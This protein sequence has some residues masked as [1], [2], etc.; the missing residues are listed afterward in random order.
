[1][2]I[3]ETFLK[4][5][6]EAVKNFGNETAVVAPDGKLTYKELDELS[7]AFSKTVK[8]H[9]FVPLEAGRSKNYIVEAIGVMKA[10]AAFVPVDP[11]YPQERKDYMISDCAN[12]VAKD[13]L[14]LMIYTSG[15]T[16]RPKGV[17]ISHSALAA[18]IAASEEN[19]DFGKGVNYAQLASFSFVMSLHDIFPLLT[20]GGCLHILDDATRKDLSALNRY[21]NENHIDGLTGNPQMGKMLIEQF[22]PKLKFMCL[23]GEKVSEMPKTDI[24]IINGYGCT[25]YTS[26][27]LEYV[28]K[29]GETNVPVGRPVAN[30]QVFICD[31]GMNVVEKGEIGELC[32]A[33]PQLAEG[34]HNREDLTAEKFVEFQG[35]RVYKTGDLARC[36]ENDDIEYCGRK[37]FL[38]KIRGFR[39]EPGEIE[40]VAK[41]CD[42]VTN[43]VA[44]DCRINGVAHIVLYYTGNADE[45]NL[46]NTLKKSLTDYMVPEF[47][48]QLD[49]IPLLPNGKTDRNHLP[50]PHF[51]EFEEEIVE[52]ANDTEKA[53]L[54]LTKNVLNTSKIG[55]T[56]HLIS[57]G[58]TSLL[59]MKL[60]VE[61][62]RQLQLSLS[63]SDILMT[64]NVRGI[65]NQ[66]VCV[67]NA[68]NQSVVNTQKTFPLTESQRGIYLDVEMEPSSLQYNLPSLIEFTN[69]KAEALKTALENVLK[70]HPGLRTRLF[71][72]NGDVKCRIEDKIDEIVIKNGEFDKSCIQPFDIMNEQLC[73]FVIFE[74]GD[75]VKLFAD[76]HHLVFDGSSMGIFVND[77]RAQLAGNQVNAENY[78]IFDFALT[79]EKILNDEVKVSAAQTYFDNLI[80]EAEATSLPAFGTADSDVSMTKINLPRPQIQDFCRKNGLTES[81]YLLTCFCQVLH[82]LTRE[83]KLL[84]TMVSSG[85]NDGKTADCIGMF[86]KTQ[87]V[88]SNMTDNF[89]DM[90][91]Q[92]MQTLSF[93]YYPFTKIAERYGL[94]SQ[95]DFV[96][97]GGIYPE[98][99]ERLEVG[100][101][102][103]PLSLNVV[104]KDEHYELQF[105]FNNKIYPLSQI[106]TLAKMVCLFGAQAVKEEFVAISLVSKEDEAGIWALSQ[107][108]TLDFDTSETWLDYFR[109]Q[110]ESQPDAVAVAD[111]STHYKYKELDEISG[112]FAAYLVKNGVM[113][114]D[115]VAIKMERCKEFIAAVVGIQKAAAAYV[116]IDAA[117][118]QERIDLMI[119]DS[120]AK[121][122]VTK[123]V[124][125]DAVK[126]QTEILASKATPDNLAYMIYTS[127]STGRP[128]GVMLHHRGLL[129]FTRSIMKSEELTKTDRTASHR[130]FSFDAH[131]GDIYPTLS[132]GAQMHIMPDDIRKD[133]QAMYDFL[134]ERQITGC[135]FTTSIAMMM[136]NNFDLPVRF[137][138]A[139]GEKLA[140]VYSEKYSIINLYGPTECTN[141]STLF[142]MKPGTRM[143]NIPIGRPLHNCTVCVMDRHQHLLP[144]GVAGE[145]CITGPQVSRGYWQLPEKTKEAFV[146]LPDGRRLYRT[147]DLGRYNEDGQMEYLG[148]IDHQVKLRGFRIELG[149]IEAVTQS[150]E[151]IEAAVAA[152]RDIHGNKHLVLYYSPKNGVTIDE[153]ALRHH[154]EGSS[155][156]EY[157]HPEIYMMLEKMPTLPNGKI[158]RKQLPEPTFSTMTEAGE[159]AP[160]NVL[161]KKIAEI[162]GEM[163]GVNEFAV[164]VPLTALGVTSLMAIKLAVRLHEVFGIEV[165]TKTIMQGATLQDIENSI[166]EMMMSGEAKSET[167][168]T[169]HEQKLSSP[170][171]AAQLGVY[172][173]CMKD[174]EN[175][176]YNV[177]TRVDFPESVTSDDIAEAVKSAL[178]SH[179][180]FLS[181]FEN[182]EETQLVYD[183]NQEL[184]VTISDKTAEENQ[185]NFIRP[186]N[187]NRGPLYR[188]VICGRTLLFDAH[189]LVMDGGSLAVFMQDVCKKLNGV[190][191]AMETYTA[192]DFASDEKSLDES[193]M[194]AFFA[195]RLKTVDGSSTIPEDKPKRND[196]ESQ[197]GTEIMPIDF[198]SVEKLAKDCGTTPAMVLLSAVQYLTARYTNTHDTC[199]CTISNGRSNIKLAHTVGMFVNTLPLVSHITDGTVSEFVKANAADFTATLDNENYPFAK[200]AADFELSPDVV[201][202]YQIGVGG[203]YEV[204]GNPLK[205][206]HFGDEKAK[207]RLAVKVEMRENQPSF[208]MYYDTAFYTRDYILRMASSLVQTVKNMTS[209]P[210]MP[211]KKI[212]IITPGQEEELSRIRQLATLDIPV[213][214]YHEGLEI[215]AAKTPEKTALIAVDRTLSFKQFNEDANRLAHLLMKKGVRKGDA[216][217]ILLPRTSWALI[218]MHGIMKTGAAYIPCDP[219]Y[220]EDRIKLILEDS[221]AKFVLTSD[222]LAPLY[223]DK[224]LTINE[225]ELAEM[226]VENPNVDIKPDDLS[227]MIYTS[228]STGR[229]K[230]V[231]LRHEGICSYLTNHPCNRHIHA[232]CETVDVYLSVSTIS[233]DLSQKEYGLCLFNGLTCVFAG[234]DQCNDPVELAKL[235]QETH[236]DCINGT[237]SRIL[238]YMELPDFCECLKHC[239]VIMSGGEKYSDKLLNR[240]HDLSKARIFNTYGPTEI[241]VSCNVAELTKTN[242]ISVGEP[243]LN[244]VEYVVDPDGNEL[245]VGVVGELTVG[246]PGVAVGYN[247]LDEL[248]A[249]KFIEYKGMRCFRTGDYAR[250]AADGK[251]WVLGRADNQVKLRGLRIELGEVET[252]ISKVEGVKNVVILIRTLQER[253]HL[254]AYFTADR[255]IDINE[256]KAQI[257]Q[258]LTNYMVP[259]AYLQMDAFPLTPNGKTDVR[260]L[261][262]AELA[263]VG[264][265]FN[266]PRNDAERFFCKVFGEIL[267]LDKVSATDSFFDLGG[268]SLVVTRVLIEAQKAGYQIVYGDVFKYKSAREL[269]NFLGVGTTEEEDPDADIRNFDY[270][271]INEVLQH[272]RNVENTDMFAHNLGTVLLTGA[273]GFLGIHILYEILKNYPESTVYCILRGKKNTSAEMR[274]RSM[275]FYYFSESFDD[276]FGT[277]L[278]VIEGDVTNEIDSSL[279]VN[280]VINCAAIVKHFS[281]GT[282]I[283]DVNVGGC[284]N[285]VDFC[286]KT[287]ARM[288]QVSTM[289][290]G[291]SSVNGVPD[292][293]SLTED[294]LYEGQRIRSQ[295]VHSKIMGERCV[296]DAVATK[297]LDGKIMRVGT[298][299]ARSTDGEYQINFQTNSFVGRLRVYH[300]LGA[301]PYAGYD[302]PVEFS[303]I[304]E[305]ATAICLLAQTPKE[306][307]VFHPFNNHNRLLGDV[308]Q[309]FN[310]DD[311]TTLKFVEVEEFSRLMQ[312]AEKDEEKQKMLS[313]LLAYNKH[314]QGEKVVPLEK[315]NRFTMQVLLR[316]GF[317]WTMT[318]D[319]YVERFFDVMRNF[320]YW[321]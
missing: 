55:V 312:E 302:M 257:S 2:K 263:A 127:G 237:P 199:I 251:V 172:F 66:A 90:Q 17:E 158:D 225:K 34:Y 107:G 19:F 291:G 296:L 133:M 284:R 149:E 33:G 160:M 42:G 8:A 270:T 260:H 181:H 232:I 275:L 264:G 6:A 256:M 189:H 209:A 314:S 115:F 292:R 27:T 136:I 114:D 80:G 267:D 182:G 32:I 174:P 54:D 35:L 307:T 83:E 7:D 31:D 46:K 89:N 147:G 259:T 126:S 104:P 14:A 272:N 91:K 161:E 197:L 269:A 129:N 96:Y 219:A 168:E 287:G 26:G 277:R 128:K 110:V 166:L 12:D 223:G 200:L 29:G 72:E 224:A 146:T 16:G 211:M 121:M 68:E 140:G 30:T 244:Y 23:G 245:P 210:D 184:D 177:P 45:D 130:S 141:D 50:E 52:A 281:Q 41:T 222:E 246:G 148:R 318:S 143:E 25:E 53:L 169:P 156:A 81:S 265:E 78:T 135:G 38:M 162:V 213:K 242:D 204:Q 310:T 15:S 198:A 112:R 10:D 21:I 87:P 239:H 216:V 283:E 243:L 84:L 278:H 20:R 317:R 250:W 214:L 261:P 268:T 100:A 36:N 206:G 207:F 202:E 124:F 117:Y 28:L 188:A 311:A 226:S 73:R 63:P 43:A 173:D 71:M 319:D 57:H 39:V 183:P 37:D 258:T 164:T 299:S 76:F 65:L 51:D 289:S 203:S 229:P 185:E 97:Q 290:V 119:D 170:L 165:R 205:I 150:F 154:I 273:T 69:V 109:R 102:M 215:Y 176:A 192:L 101:E 220:P 152:V 95:I 47:F 304:N 190:E 105:K 279:Q 252:A 60:S 139:G 306:Y 70:A 230:G 99:T 315:S 167:A 236:A 125:D 276:L 321:E 3:M 187:L 111:G 297:G 303:P 44:K 155:L 294:M 142:V 22:A 196:E 293:K 212:S 137:I 103:F 320:N 179:P 145:I 253:E 247:H 138:T 274:L 171:S 11:S 132:A 298:L 175:V 113:P 106:E 282:E 191:P 227:Y 159:S 5:F 144:Q 271:A 122:L 59:A 201:Y 305:V 151:G 235:M 288:I 79:E 280:T 286:L 88:V 18:M 228:G 234:D 238:Q 13:G 248:N 266:E 118:P 94:K 300:M 186:F 157:M 61:M 123:Q 48:V 77:L 82:R 313:A 255:P 240:L 67:E 74:N 1:M 86:V 316:M 241:T 58:L 131:I 208:V 9:T 93:D 163:T 295:Y 221:E 309:D 262:D 108:E 180:A 24:K 4:L 49:E 195:E 218:A 75:N 62:S 85:R 285:C 134:C 56:S 254:C 153:N 98:N 92:V 301:F 217:A 194:K 64:P 231:M 233:F 116:P 193:A 40:N 249:Q 178:K 120:G 308:V